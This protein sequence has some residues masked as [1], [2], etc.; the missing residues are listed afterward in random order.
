[1]LGSAL[2]DRSVFAQS[3]LACRMLQPRVLAV[4]RTAAPSP[5]ARK[6][7]RVRRALERASGCAAVPV[8]AAP[9]RMRSFLAATLVI[10]VMTAG[11][12]PCAMSPV[13]KPVSQHDCC[14]P[15]QV[16]SAATDA[17]APLLAGIPADC[18]LVMPAQ[19]AA[20]LPAAVAPVKSQDVAIAVAPDV[21]HST[22]S[23]AFTQAI[24]FRARSSPR[25]PLVTVLL[26]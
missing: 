8:T 6:I 3:H 4:A 9:V 2:Q 10:A 13:S 21:R 22:R 25:P 14:D 18:C 15:E 23:A 1:M 19:P 24:D 11:V 17:S 5:D 12:A 26:I 7:A 16:A 20:D